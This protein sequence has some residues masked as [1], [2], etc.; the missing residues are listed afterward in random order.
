LTIRACWLCKEAE[1]SNKGMN[2]RWKLPPFRFLMNSLCFIGCV[3]VAGK[4]G[5]ETCR[6]F[7]P[8]AHL[9]QQLKSRQSV[10]TSVSVACRSVQGRRPA[11]FLGFFVLEPKTF[12][13]E[14]IAVQFVRPI[15][16]CVSMVAGIRC[17]LAAT[18]RAAYPLFFLP[19]F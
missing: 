16:L 7:H 3:V 1:K 15:L 13:V 6:Y 8:P 2:G 4:C 10:N 12:V 9:V 18:V 17:P 11:I 19:Q 5:R 14:L